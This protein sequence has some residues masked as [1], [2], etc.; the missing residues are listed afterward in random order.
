[1]PDEKRFQEQARENA[2]LARA[3]SNGARA[4][5]SQADKPDFDWDKAID[6]FKR[7]LK[8]VGYNT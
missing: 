8:R 5:K 7:T 1:M 4:T 2:R 6:L 3:R